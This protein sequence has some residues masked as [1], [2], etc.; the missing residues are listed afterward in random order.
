MKCP[1]INPTVQQCMNC[2]YP[3]CIKDDL[4]LAEYQEDVLP[5]EVPESVRKARIRANRYAVKHKEEIRKRAL[6]YYRANKEKYHKR[7]I[8]WCKE[9]RERV[10]A[11]ARERYHRNIEYRRQYQRDYRARKK[12]GRQA[13]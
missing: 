4:S 1:Y 7:S 10:N 6:E 11:A 8:Q 9:N 3:D 12:A 13:V 5:V 2:P